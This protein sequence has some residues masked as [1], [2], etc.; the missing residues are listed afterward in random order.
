MTFYDIENMDQVCFMLFQMLSEI[1]AIIE[2][3]ANGPG[4]PQVSPHHSLSFLS[5]H[6]FTDKINIIKFIAEVL[7]SLFVLPTPKGSS[8]DL[9]NI[10]IWQQVMPG[11][12]FK[13]SMI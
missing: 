10:M 3:P 11:Q 6:K 13:T 9:S 1:L 8:V 2:D 7:I 12:L 4:Y 5:L